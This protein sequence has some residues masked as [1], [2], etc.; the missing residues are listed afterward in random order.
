[1][2]NANYLMKAQQEA[3]D[4]QMEDGLWR[5]LPALATGSIQRKPTPDVLCEAGVIAAHCDDYAGLLY[6]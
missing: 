5:S 6:T 3:A 1:M 2:C 4:I